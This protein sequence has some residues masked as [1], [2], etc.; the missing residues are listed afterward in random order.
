VVPLDY[1]T[2]VEGSAGLKHYGFH[3]VKTRHECQSIAAC[4]SWR[5]VDRVFKTATFGGAT[6]EKSFLQPW[7]R[8]SR[9][10]RTFLIC[11]LVML[12]TGSRVAEGGGAVTGSATFPRLMGMN[13]GAK[14][15]DDAD[16]QKELSRLDV[17]ILGF[18]KG[19]RPSGY[20]P[21]ATL[22]M[23]KAGDALRG[24]VELKLVRA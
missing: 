20:A 12:G 10:R 18:Y 13:I 14:N 9:R 16:Y 23:R 4:C 8:D 1:F 5:N 6:G 22:A 3:S 17:V 2:K 7:I 11:A 21:S 19:W 15:Y 24:V